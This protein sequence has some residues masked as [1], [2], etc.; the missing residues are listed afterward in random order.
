M[1]TTD[2]SNAAPVAPSSLWND[3]F[4]RL[5]ENRLALAGL[6][7]FLFVSVLCY[8]GPLL[9][10]HDPDSQVLALEDTLPFTRVALLEVRYDASKPTPDEVTTLADFED[11][12][13]LTPKTDLQRILAQGRATVN[14]IDFTLIE[15]FHP[16]GTDDRG[17][18]LLA[19]IMRGGRVSIG[20]GFLATL[21]ALIIGVAYG[22]IS[23]YLGGRIDAFMMR[24]VDILYALPFFIFVVLL[25][26]LFEGFQH[27]ILLVFVAIGVVEWLT[28]ARIA[29]GQVV[30]LKEQ[31]FVI[32]AQ[33][34]G[35]RPWKIITRHIAPNLLGT[36]VVYA[37]LLVPSVI[38]LES[39]LSF[40]GLGMEAKVASWGT[41]IH[42]GQK[43]MST[44]PWTLIAPSLFFSGTL[45]AL[46]VLGDG[47]RDA[48]DVKSDRR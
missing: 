6:G 34:I 25:M 9:Y 20:V 47:L 41:L 35:V 22:S 5:S 4:H 16:L 14:G 45:F 23:G 28:M 15:R 17:R 46:N 24:S 40:L 19:R 3:A 37:T 13:A 11:V 29:R 38:L 26:V 43:A 33:A 21:T 42:E 44:A 36:V 7:F 8:L 2:Q 31:E 1:A 39:T 48:L 30:A 27:K 12:Y 10:H 18:D 32:A